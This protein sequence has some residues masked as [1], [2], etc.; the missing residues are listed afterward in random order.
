MARSRGQ[1]IQKGRERWLARIFIGRDA[2][3]RR[4]YTSKLIEGTKTD[5]RKELDRLL[6]DRANGRIVT[7]P[8]TLTVGEWADQWLGAVVKPSTRRRTHHDYTAEVERNIKPHFGVLPLRRLGPSQV[9]AWLAKLREPKPA[10]SGLGSRSVRKSHEVLRNMLESAVVDGLLVDNPARSRL[11]K[12]ALPKK[13]RVERR[14]V[15]T[16]DVEAFL[17]AALHNEWG[18]YWTLQLFSGLRPGESLA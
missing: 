10:G 17:E 13:E 12:K 8:R 2:E 15:G 7:T 9:R 16:G 14:V 1:L 11:V 6:A 4:K 3:G 5:A 18:A